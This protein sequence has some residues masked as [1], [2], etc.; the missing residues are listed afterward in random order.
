MSDQKILTVSDLASL[1]TGDDR[2]ELDNGKLVE[3]PLLEDLHSVTHTLIISY[4]CYEGELQNFGQSRGRVGIILRRNPDRVVGPDAAFIC[5]RS[6]PVRRSKEGY[7][8]TIPEIV[9]EVRS[10][11]DT[12]AEIESKVAEYHE[13]GVEVVWILDPYQQTVTVLKN[14]QST[15]K[16]SIED[17][18]TAEGL[19]PDF[20]V[21]IKNLFPE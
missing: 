16:L 4:L 14:G 10:K 20:A 5:K 18:L 13:A 3:S 2:Y 21:P 6:L 11:N 8:E 12:D 1:P 19:I 17:T 9:V 15:L 7:L